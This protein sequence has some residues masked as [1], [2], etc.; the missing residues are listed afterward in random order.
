[1]KKEHTPLIPNIAGRTGIEASHLSSGTMCMNCKQLGMIRY[2]GWW[3][4]LNCGKRA[5]YAH[6]YALRDHFL[7]I[8]DTIST[9]SAMWWLGIE[10]G[11]STRK[12]LGAT[13]GVQ[14]LGKLKHG[15]NLYSLN[16]KHNTHYEYLEE[17][18]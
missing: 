14:I 15:E 1:M 17:F 7:L 4:C 5:R 12:V 8:G 3:R 10:S 18:F 2:N 16:Y 6:E 11:S 13:S 9:S